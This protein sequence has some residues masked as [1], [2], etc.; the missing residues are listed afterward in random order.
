M[1]DTSLLLDPFQNI[2]NVHWTKKTPAPGP[3]I[4]YV[5]AWV[6]IVWALGQS[7]DGFR[8]G[9]AVDSTGNL[10]NGRFP[11]SAGTNYPGEPASR[12]G[13]MSIML[14]DAGT[15]GATWRV[16]DSEANSWQF[17]AT[18]DANF[19][20]DVGGIYTPTGITTPFYDDSN[21]MSTPRVLL[22][23]WT[24]ILKKTN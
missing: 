9:R 13:A 5:G 8:A 17:T 10:V 12:I 23:R 24:I 4:A 15:T 11:G 2:V 20:S 16:S 7:T 6:E 22:W 3:A 21:G 18:W 19:I 1:G 14:E